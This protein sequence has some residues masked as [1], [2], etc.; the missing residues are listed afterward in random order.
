[1][2]GLW[3]RS[4]IT[5]ILTMQS[6]PVTQPGKRCENCGQ[7]KLQPRR[8]SVIAIGILFAF[9]AA[10][11][12]PWNPFFEVPERILGLIA[13]ALFITSVFVKGQICTNCK[14]QTA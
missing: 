11:L 7:F 2:A 3:Q 10:L 5:N 1:M 14:A 8:I 9:I 13:L 12:V 6:K 4:K